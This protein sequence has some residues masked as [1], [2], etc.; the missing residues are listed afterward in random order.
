[1][2]RQRPSEAVVAQVQ[3]LGVSRES[4]DRV[5]IFVDLLLTWQARMNLIS[6]ASIPHIWERHVFDCSAGSS[7]PARYRR[8]DG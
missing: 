8:G 2:T 5:H 1:M 3:A 6:P 7:A 4:W